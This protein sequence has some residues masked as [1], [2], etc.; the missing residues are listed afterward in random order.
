MGAI[1]SLLVVVATS[2][3]ITRIA[4]S[5]LVMTGVSRELANFQA[6]SA[7]T[8]GRVHYRRSRNR[9]SAWSPAKDHPDLDAPRERRSGWSHRLSGGWFCSGRL[10]ANRGDTT[11]GPDRR[12]GLLWWMTTLDSIERLLRRTIERG[13]ERWT[14]LHVL[15][16]VQLLGMERGYEVRELKVM[17]GDW[18]AHNSLESL[19]LPGE[20][21]LILA[22]RRSNGAYLGAPHPRTEIV[23]GDTTLPT[24]DPTTSQNWRTG[25]PVGKAIRHV[26]R[27][28]L[29]NRVCKPKRPKTTRNQVRVEHSAEIAQPRTRLPMS[30][31]PGPVSPHLTVSHLARPTAAP[32]AHEFVLFP[33]VTAV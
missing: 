19:D 15:D 12:L 16:Y 9:G 33:L 8:G 5:A 26:N 10:A 13:L 28:L 14:D 30:F 32:Q 2:V 4:T 7:Y 3:L 29:R 1:A 18:L 22:L 31:H 25:E 11:R 20:G 27:P 21:V 23:P 17:E 24:G 6:R